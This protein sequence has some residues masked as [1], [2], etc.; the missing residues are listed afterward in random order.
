MKYI[1]LAEEMCFLDAKTYLMTSYHDRSCVVLCGCGLS[2]CYLPQST[3]PV[4]PT[5]R[6]HAQSQDT[7]R[8]I[9]AK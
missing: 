4:P 1:R 6:L 3:I 2:V 8:C 5:K 9:D 7:Y